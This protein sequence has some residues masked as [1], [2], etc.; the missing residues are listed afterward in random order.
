MAEEKMAALA[1]LDA[2]I[3]AATALAGLE[4]APGHRAGVRA[5]LETGLAIAGRIGEA[6][7]E[8]APTFRP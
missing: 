5:H 1:P 6:G 3:E 8:A 4:I 7:R 2:A